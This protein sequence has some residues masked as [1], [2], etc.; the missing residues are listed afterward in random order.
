MPAPIQ[1]QPDLGGEAAW[2]HGNASVDSAN[3]ADLLTC[4]VFRRLQA[5]AKI[6]DSPD[7]TK[8]ANMNCEAMLRAIENIAP[9]SLSHHDHTALRGI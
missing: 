1:K 9:D 7:P 8:L 5:L 3:P 2:Q 6:T 4:F